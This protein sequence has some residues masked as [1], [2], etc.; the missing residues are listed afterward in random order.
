MSKKVPN[1]LFSSKCV[2]LLLNQRLFPHRRPQV[3]LKL[4]LRARTE[5]QGS[6]VDLDSDLDQRAGMKMGIIMPDVRG[7]SASTLYASVVQLSS[8]ASFPHKINP[9]QHLICIRR[10]DKQAWD[11]CVACW[12]MSRLLVQT[13][14]GGRGQRGKKLRSAYGQSL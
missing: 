4:Q 8:A 2:Y 3:K 12:L 7:T 11:T 13:E 6:D 10:C 9:T 14:R 1:D 5:T